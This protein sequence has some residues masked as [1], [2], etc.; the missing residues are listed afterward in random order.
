MEFNCGEGK[1]GSSRLS[2]RCLSDVGCKTRG[3][4]G[5]VWMRRDIENKG[6]KLKKI[7]KIHR[8]RQDE[9]SHALL[10]QLEYTYSGRAN[11]SLPRKRGFAIDP[12]FHVNKPYQAHGDTP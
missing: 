12:E 1:E 2:A 3:L 8:R 7:S 11:E 4:Q 5:E 10:E 6:Y 9:V